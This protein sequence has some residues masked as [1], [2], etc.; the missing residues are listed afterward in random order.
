MIIL[1]IITPLNDV[2]HAVRFIADLTLE[3]NIKGIGNFFNYYLRHDEMLSDV[4]KVLL[5]L[6]LKLKLPIKQAFTQ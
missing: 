2:N 6:I 3:N 4:F 5:N 1:Y